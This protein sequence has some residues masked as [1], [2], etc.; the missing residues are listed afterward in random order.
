MP[1]GPGG[2]GAMPRCP[3]AGPAPGY[4]AS[5]PSISVTTAS[6]LPGRPCARAISARAAPWRVPPVRRQ[7]QRPRRRERRSRLRARSVSPSA[8][9]QLSSRRLHCASMAL[10]A[11]SPATARPSAAGA[12]ACGPGPPRRESAAHPPRCRGHRSRAR[13]DAPIETRRPPRPV[14]RAG[15]PTRRGC[16]AGRRRSGI[17]GRP[18][19]PDGAFQLAACGAG[20]AAHA[21]QVLAP[22]RICMRRLLGAPSSESDVDLLDR[23]PLQVLT[24]RLVILIVESGL[25]S[26]SGC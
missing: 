6:A 13:C 17:A 19:D 10:S 23:A 22:F 4:F 3:N 18:C 15:P 26:E 12:M 20:L 24:S 21:R 9:R 2:T 11:T 14:A 16:R 25:A 7:H 8:A 1:R 5:Q